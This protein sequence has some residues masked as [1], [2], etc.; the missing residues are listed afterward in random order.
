MALIPVRTDLPPVEGAEHAL[1]RAAGLAKDI[2]DCLE[3]L[4]SEP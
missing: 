4:V 2:I 1:A 3:A